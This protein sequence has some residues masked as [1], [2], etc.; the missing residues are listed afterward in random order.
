MPE[1]SEATASRGRSS[2]R[3][4][5]GSGGL[6][7]SGAPAANPLAGRMMLIVNPVAGAGAAAG[8]SAEL[9]MALRDLGLDF[10][11]KYTERSGHA[12]GIASEAARRGYGTVA[13]VGGDGTVREAVNGLM[14]VERLARPAL[15]V[16]PAGMGADFCRTVGIPGD[17]QIAATL[18]ASGKRRTIDVG[19]MEYDTPGG[20]CTGYF[21]NVAG[22]GFDGEVTGRAARLPERLRKAVGGTGCYLLSTALT[23]SKYLEKDVELHVDEKTYRALATTVVV[24]NCRYFGG[25]MKVAPDAAPDD[26]LFDVIVI[27]AG[28]GSTLLDL[29]PDSAPPVRSRLERSG[30]KARTARNVTRIYRG[31]HTEDPSV[32]TMRAGAVRVIS[33]DRMVLQADGD[34][35]GSGPFAA[36]VIPGAI[37]V[38]GVRHFSSHLPRSST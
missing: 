8:I 29:P 14:A 21:A 9:E 18:L 2:R 20:L 27:G 11:R 22:L 34:V 35:I 38:I 3:K 12:A 17:W 26:G 31:T 1:D 25:R 36:K 4:R 13:V 33:N 28:F 10:D 37:D 15:G 19:W 5:K 24:A 32:V 16:I 7:I 23:S 30:A 6:K